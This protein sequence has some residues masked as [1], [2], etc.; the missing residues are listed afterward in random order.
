MP[1]IF[2]KRRDLIFMSFYPFGRFGSNNPFMAYLE[3]IFHLWGN[4]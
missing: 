1:S 2:V 3:L 4:I